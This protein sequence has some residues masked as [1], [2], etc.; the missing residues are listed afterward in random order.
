MRKANKQ[1]RLPLGV[2][3][4]VAVGAMAALSPANATGISGTF[5]GT[6]FQQ[7]PRPL[8]SPDHVLVS[9][10]C[11]ATNA[12][13][14]GP[15]DGDAVIF[16]QIVDL[17]RGNGPQTGE[18]AFIDKTGSLTAEYR[19]MIK[20]VLVDGQPRTTADGT[21]RWVHGTGVYAGGSGH[22]MA[23]S[24]PVHRQCSSCDGGSSRSMAVA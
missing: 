14:G 19:G 17:N 16:S 11:K 9:Q 20:T 23:L 1:T 8:E 6:C 21:Y 5:T 12:N 15:F 22:G 10:L 3:P 7:D 2:W 18:N 13:P 4:L 24:I